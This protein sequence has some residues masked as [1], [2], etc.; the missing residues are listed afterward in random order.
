MDARALPPARF[1]ATLQAIFGLQGVVAVG[2]F[3]ASGL[4]DREV[5]LLVITYAVALPIGW[6]LGALVFHRL[7]PRQFRIGVLSMLVLSASV[8]LVTAR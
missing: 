6:R 4:V 3:A 8:A 1:R 2:L 5:G 7:S